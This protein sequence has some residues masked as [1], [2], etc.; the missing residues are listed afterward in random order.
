MLSGRRPRGWDAKITILA[1]ETPE[2]SRVLSLK[3]AAEQNTA[4][5]ALPTAKDSAF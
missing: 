4:F 5:H 1:A 2:L 3:P